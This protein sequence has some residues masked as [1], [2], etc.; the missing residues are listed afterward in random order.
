M[1][2][3]L[4]EMQLKNAAKSLLVDNILKYSIVVADCNPRETHPN[5]HGI[6]DS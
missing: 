2:W 5:E 6:N 3:K 4:A 1:Y